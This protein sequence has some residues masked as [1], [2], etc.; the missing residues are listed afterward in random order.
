MEIKT[1]DR[2]P[3]FDLEAAWPDRVRL[4]DFLG[5]HN[6]LLVF[7]P[8]AFTP[9]CEEEALDLQENIEAFRNANTEI[10]FVSC[11]SSAARQAW[12]RQLGAEYVFAS[13][14][15]PHGEAARAYGVFDEEKG[16]PARGTFLIDTEGTVVWSLVK[17]DG[18]R[19]DDL[20]P[21]SL[22]AVEDAG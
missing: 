22:G 9:V 2:A 20:V 4:S 11:D 3:E 1:G 10:V 17:R 7:H 15:W 14:F 21:G 5:R 16:T 6:V 19:R 13:D 12:R 18:T 8:L